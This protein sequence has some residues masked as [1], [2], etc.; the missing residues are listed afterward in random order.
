MPNY[1]AVPVVPDSIQRS[2]TQHFA[3]NIYVWDVVELKYVNVLRAYP[4]QRQINL[5]LDCHRLP[6]GRLG[7]DAYVLTVVSLNCLAD[8][9]FAIN[10][11]MGRVDPV[12]TD[13]YRLAHDRDCMVFV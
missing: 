6:G 8:K 4:S 7:K 5:L 12:E 9:F 2:V 10:V 11:N 3:P 1:P 13:I